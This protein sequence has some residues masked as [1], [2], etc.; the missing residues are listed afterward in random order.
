MD[1]I[2]KREYIEKGKK[3]GNI[4][5]KIVR[6]IILL[7]VCYYILYPLIAKAMLS[8]MD[9]SNLYD[10]TVGLIPKDFSLTT[11]RTV[12]ETMNYPSAFMGTVGVTLITTITQTVSCVL[13]GY[14]FARYDFPFKRILFGLVIFTLIV[15]PS[16]FVIPMY[17]NFR[18]FDFAGGI[19]NQFT[20]LH[21]NLVGSVMTFVVSGITCMGFKNGLYIFLVR[22]YFRNVPKELEEAAM[23]DGAGFFKTFAMIMTPSAK[24]I[25][26][27]VVMFSFVWQWTDIFYSSWFMRDAMI[28]SRRLDILAMNVSIRE[29]GAGAGVV[30]LDLNYLTQLN[31]IGGLMVII[32]LIIL[33]VF[34]QKIF[35]ESIERSGIVG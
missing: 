4:L 21:V 5:Y 34:G 6:A 18:F 25:L 30:N 19:L 29:A 28:L 17:L 10:S 12:F 22:Q 1:I 15:P 3:A 13:V 26:S 31:S 16:I 24:P 23:I 20:G 14:G 27:V 33:F 2:K 9:T 35:V 11:I 7:G 8:I 32:P